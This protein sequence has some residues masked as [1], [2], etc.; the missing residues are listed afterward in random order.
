MISSITENLVYLEE[1]LSAMSNI[2]L[3][4]QDIHVG[5]IALV[6]LTSGKSIQGEVLEISDYVLI[7]KED[8]KTMRLLDG[9]IGGWELI[10]SEQSFKS[11]TEKA[12][13]AITES[14]QLR[15]EDAEGGKKQKSA[16]SVCKQ[17][18][19]EIKLH[20]LGD[21][22]DALSSVLADAK[23]EEGLKTLPPL[24]RVKFM[25]A[26]FLFITDFSS[27]Q[28]L[29]APIS[30]LLEDDIK[31]GTNVIYSYGKSPKGVKAKSIHKSTTTEDALNL[32]NALHVSGEQRKALEVLKHILDI[33]PH[34]V[35]ASE[36]LNTLRRAL[37]RKTGNEGSANSF[38][39]KSTNNQRIKAIDGKV[40]MPQTGAFPE[41]PDIVNSP[42]TQSAL[43]L[44]LPKMTDT[45][46]RE[47]EK[48]LDALIRNGEREVC[49]AI[50]YELLS[51][52]CPTPKYLRSYLDRIV[53]TEV[54]L[55]HTSEAISALAQLI[56]FSES[57]SDTK[58]ANLSHLYVFMARLLKKINNPEEAEKA[59][60]CAEYLGANDTVIQGLREQIRNIVN[61][62][63]IDQLNVSDS[64]LGTE[65]GLSLA[66]SRMLQQDVETIATSM[67]ADSSPALLLKR[68]LV[69]SAPSSNKTFEVKAQF[70][71]EAAA[72]FWIR[73]EVNSKDYKSAV[74]N[75]ARMKGNA[76]FTRLQ[77]SIHLF[78]ENKNELLAYSD[79]ACSYYTE[80][81]GIFNELKQ[82]QYLQELFLK[83]LKLRRVSSQILGERTPDTEWDKGTLKAMLR[84]CL[85]G[86]DPEDFK[87]FVHTCISV[88]TSTEAA[89]NSLCQDV[90]GTGPFIGRL[91]DDG[92]R[93]R[94]FRLFNDI[95]G[96]DV[97]TT[98]KA[99]AFLHTV[100][101]HRQQRNEQ[102]YTFLTE[103]TKWEFDP[104]DINSISEKWKQ[105]DDYL[106]IL[107][108]SDVR[109]CT[110][111]SDVINILLDYTESDPIYRNNLLIQAQQAIQKNIKEIVETT[112]FLGRVFFAPLESKWLDRINELLSLYYASKEPRLKITPDPAKI[113]HDDSGYSVFFRVSNVGETPATS[114]TVTII[115]NRDNNWQQIDN[116]RL[117]VGEEKIIQWQIP[118]SFYTE[119]ERESRLILTL[120][121]TPYFQGRTLKSSKDEFV[122]EIES[123]VPLERKEIPW[124]IEATPPGNIFKGRDKEL[125]KLVSHYKSSERGHTYI[126][127]G[128]TRTGKTSMLE[129]LRGRL[130]NVSLDESPETS[131]LPFAWDF[132]KVVF[133]KSQQNQFWEHLVKTQIYNELPAELR[134]V[135]NKTYEERRFPDVVSQND[136]I[137]LIDTLNSNHIHPFITIDEFSNVKNGMESGM[138]NASFLGILRD[139]ALTGK[140]S[141]IYAGTY[142]IKELPNDPKYGYTGQLAHTLQMP[143]NAIEDTYADELIDAWDKLHFEVDAKSYIRYLSGCVPYWI[144]W[145]CLNCGKY[146]VIHQKHYLGVH[147]V[148]EVVQIMTGEA[149]DEEEI[150]TWGKIDEINFQNNQ[151]MTDDGKPAEEALISSIAYLNR[152]N[153]R[154]ARGISTKELDSLW[155]KN[156]VSKAFQGEMLNAIK[157][158][159]VRD[160][161]IEETEDN[162]LVYRLAV[163][164]FRRCW[165][166]K[167]MNISTELSHK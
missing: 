42:E 132:N 4:K 77:N 102:L 133:D 144:Q 120:E 123:S 76:M 20:R 40:K 84:D 142:D 64:Q 1:E 57:Q 121:A 131:I 80:A 18:E 155:E 99:T 118:E 115:D 3:F 91:N 101:S 43:P 153:L 49:L 69:E 26:N 162:R 34:N 70:F 96:S 139:L 27:S 154:R 105:I 109:T 150:Y 95:E 21:S 87:A 127:Y 44:S 100:F 141:F 37:F 7:K 116:E 29:Y 104:I 149:R 148:D 107:L 113:R 98:L 11:S 54:A 164:L 90:D 125:S 136:F 114:F 103:V 67:S 13:D 50:S 117:S 55:N 33:Y 159:K 6:E 53:N 38:I 16:S 124:R 63:A 145:I 10:E 75:Y 56:Y 46:C 89:W 161:M 59:L 82:P 137:K 71:L 135:V 85:D 157:R 106:G 15:K 163:D 110:K 160:T 52:R 61:N 23:K 129:Y 79:S 147:D 19:S 165:Y 36:L 74:A 111:I 24:G 45:E 97:S 156:N 122:F 39:K 151:V 41:K 66:V 108:P 146:A 8:G 2:D 94:T 31:P 138:L 32:A 60:N 167:H 119:I 83:Y 62:P 65:T 92:F 12:E 126:L 112:T 22:L 17:K 5:D 78:P 51:K 68:A 166:V 86:E 88:G 72:C 25:A 58:S 130:K 48:E 140:A 158:M 9:I 93:L 81:L 14:E 30:E 28:D 128:L 35:E 143:I 134:M 73:K 47:K 152:K